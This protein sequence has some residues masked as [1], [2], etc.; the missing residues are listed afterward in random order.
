MNTLPAA[1][2]SDHGGDHVSEA[3][4]GV[5]AALLTAIPFAVRLLQALC[6]PLVLHRNVISFERN[7]LHG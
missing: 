2:A 1:T 5:H 3:N 7:V 4:N 6:I